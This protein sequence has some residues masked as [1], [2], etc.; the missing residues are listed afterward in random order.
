MSPEVL[1]KDN[2][3]KFKTTVHD[4]KFMLPFFFKQD[5]VRTK[6]SLSYFLEV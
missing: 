4:A 2:N 6:E 5:P 3:K 1:D